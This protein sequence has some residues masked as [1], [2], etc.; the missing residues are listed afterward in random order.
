MNKDL[1]M[2]GA[3]IGAIG[4]TAAYIAHPLCEHVGERIGKAEEKDYSL[5]ARGK[6]FV[7]GATKSLIASTIGAAAGALFCLALDKASK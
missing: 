5:K 4:G 7:G 6:V 3:V 1:I 2:A